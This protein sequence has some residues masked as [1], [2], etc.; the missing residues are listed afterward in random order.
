MKYEKKRVYKPLIV[1]PY[2]SVQKLAKQFSVDDKTV[3]NALQFISR[4][5]QAAHIRDEALKM[6]GVTLVQ[7]PV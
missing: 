1:Y 3:R 6:P 4:S 5:E 7:I 2:G